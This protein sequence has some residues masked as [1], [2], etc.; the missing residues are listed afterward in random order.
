[1]IDT[2]KGFHYTDCGLD[3]I[4]LLNG[5]ELQSTPYGDGYSIQDM[6]GLHDAIA[7][8]IVTG[9]TMRG[10]EVRFLRSLLDLSQSGLAEILGVTRD[11]I[12]K[13]ET[14]EPTKTINK[15][16]DRTLRMFFALE[17]SGHDL[18]KRITGLLSELDDFKFSESRF[19]ANDNGDWH[20]LAA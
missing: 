16:A 11:A 19:E 1:M 8:S 12:A 2:A 3:N 10:Q 13:W 7:R 18:A 9:P 17:R 4:W 5:Y 14:R 6:D 15:S 20:R